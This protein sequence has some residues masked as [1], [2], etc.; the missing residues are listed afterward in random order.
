LFNANYHELTV[1]YQSIIKTTEYWIKSEKNTAE[2]CYREPLSG[3]FFQQGKRDNQGN[4][5]KEK[6]WIKD[7]II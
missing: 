5:K 3:C 7:I 1:N 6:Q 4:N 2:P